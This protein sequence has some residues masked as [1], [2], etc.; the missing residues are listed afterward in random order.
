MLRATTPIRAATAILIALLAIGSHPSTTQAAQPKQPTKPP[1]PARTTATTP[2]PTQVSIHPGRYIGGHAGLVKSRIPVLPELVIV[3]HDHDYIDA[4]AGWDLNGR[5][6]VLIDDGSHD[7]RHNIA[8][9]IRAFQP[10]RVSLYQ[11]KPPEQ[12]PERA[13]REQQL[14]QT[15]ARAWGATDT[16]SLKQRW[17]Q[18]RFNPFGLVVTTWNDTSWTGALA[19]AAGHGQLLAFIDPVPGDPSG[20]MPP[21]TADRIDADARAA[22]T[23]AGFSHASLGNDID[24]VTIALN[25]PVKVLQQD[26][27]NNEMLALTD[28][29]GRSPTEPGRRW[30]YTGQLLGDHAD[31]AYRAMCSLFLKLDS[32]WLFDGYESTHP[33]NQWDMTDTAAPLRDAGFA[34]ELDDHR[35]GLSLGHWRRRA[36]GVTEAERLDQHPPRLGVDA[37]LI[38]VTTSGNAPWFDLKPGRALACDVPF[39]RTPACVYFVHSWSAARPTDRATVAGRWLERGAF[40]YLGSVHEPYLQAFVPTPHFARHMLPATEQTAQAGEVVIP[41]MCLGAAVRMD[42]R[43]P[44]KVTL[45]GDPLFVMTE[46]GPRDISKRPPLDNLAD[47]TALA[48]EALREKRFPDAIQ[49]FAML[50]RDQ[51]TA[52]IVRSLVRDSPDAITEDAAIAAVVPLCLTGD[53]DTLAELWP[54]IED[55][56]DTPEHAWLKDAVW[57]TAWGRL[58]NLT[59]EQ[60]VMLIGSI[61]DEALVRDS[62]ETA[63]ALERSVNKQAAAALL[64]KMKSRVES[65]GDRAKLERAKPR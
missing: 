8:R 10:S 46:T 29:V 24:A 45:L 22:V 19:L 41:P 40:A 51:D 38:C 57:H 31:S 39:L 63:R 43:P 60:S 37:G 52:R 25:C 62:V 2:A 28:T 17:K 1:E 58:T 59:K 53:L 15:V 42:N 3:R 11:T 49:R 9:F 65:A 48:R 44:W 61:R 6:P 12:T 33:W 30:A 50:A 20:W 16:E 26:T 47:L 27:P 56:A 14:Q 36:S 32:A 7:A 64:D 13:Q 34:V 55:L 4:I 54:T 5:Y 23:E 21:Q 35:A 18:L